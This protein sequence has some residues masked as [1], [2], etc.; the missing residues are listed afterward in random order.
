MSISVLQTP[1]AYAFAGNPM[2]VNV[3]GTNNISGSYQY[4]FT[5]STDEDLDGVYVQRILDKKPARP[6]GYGLVA[7]LTQLN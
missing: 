4:G 6:D 3:S 7:V 1:A 2:W 5:V